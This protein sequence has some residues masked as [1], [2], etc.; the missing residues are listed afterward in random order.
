MLEILALRVWIKQNPNVI[1]CI[2]YHS[3]DLVNA[4]R[5]EKQTS[6]SLKFGITHIVMYWHIIIYLEIKRSYKFLELIRQVKILDRLITQ[7][8]IYVKDKSIY[9]NQ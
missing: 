3:K 6:S 1:V 8:N 7:I 5:Q 2:K 9:K 4:T